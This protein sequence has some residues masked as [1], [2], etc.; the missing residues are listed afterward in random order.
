MREICS[1]AR[2]GCGNG[3]AF[4]RKGPG[5]LDVL[6][7]SVR[8]A[9][10]QIRSPPRRSLPQVSDDVQQ[11]MEKLKAAAAEAEYING[12]ERN[13]GWAATKYTNIARVRMVMWEK[14]GCEGQ[15]EG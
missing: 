15:G 13:F 1:G 7:S 14:E 8:F 10:P 3:T 12:Q 5:G 9:L 2:Q 4:G 6:L 11:L